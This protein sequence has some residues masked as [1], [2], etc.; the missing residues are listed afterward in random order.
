MAAI[1]LLKGIE[2]HE[3]SEYVF[4][5]GTGDSFFQGTKGIWQ[6]IVK[7]ANLPGVTPHTLRH[8]VGA[9]ATSSGEALALTG[10]MLGHSNLR[11]TM[12]YAHVDHDPSVKAANRVSDRI[13]LAMAGTVASADMEP[14]PG[15]ASGASGGLLPDDEWQML[16]SLAAVSTQDAGRLSA[17]DNPVLAKLA[18]HGFAERARVL[19]DQLAW[20]KLTAV[21]QAVL[22]AAAPQAEAA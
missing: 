17:I 10:A 19:N 8:T 18:L 5:A 3:D 9:V 1:T 12:I 11:S 15:E 2:R 16:I 22:S 7:E 4:P 21:G 13:S 6:K 14:K 20:W